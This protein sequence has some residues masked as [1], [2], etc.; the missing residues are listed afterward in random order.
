MKESISAYSKQKSIAKKALK[1]AGFENIKISN[2][3]YSFSG[4]AT[5][6]EKIIYFSI[7]DV[8]HEMRNE[9]MIR[10]AKDYRDFTGG[11]NCFCQIDIESIQTL[12]NRLIGTITIHS[13]KELA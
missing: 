10:T 3:Y 11:G 1:S 8:R 12:A 6:N 5:K 2:G 7:P 13:K 4:F 9:L